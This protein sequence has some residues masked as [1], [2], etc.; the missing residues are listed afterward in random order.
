MTTS[1]GRNDTL[2]PPLL[3]K[4]TAVEPISAR[5]SLIFISIS[6]IFKTQFSCESTLQITSHAHTY[7]KINKAFCFDKWAFFSNFAFNMCIKKTS[8]SNMKWFRGLVLMLLLTITSALSAQDETVADAESANDSEAVANDS[9]MNH[10]DI[11]LITC[12]PHDMIYALYGHTGIRIH[13]LQ[14]GEDL[15]ANW[16]I[17]DQ[18]QSFF[19]VRF[20]FGLTDYR[21]EIETWEG[22]VDRY[23]YFNCGIYE[24]V[25]DLTAQEKRNII[26]AVFENYLPENR[27]YRYNFYYDNCTT[28]ARDIIEKGLEGKLDYREMKEFTP[29]YRELIHLWNENHLWARW[30]NDFLL[31]VGS[32]KAT[33]YRQQQ[34]L[35]DNLK[36]DFHR[37][38][39][40]RNGEA[41]PLVKNEFWA[42]PSQYNY[43]GSSL[44][45]QF[46]RPDAVAVYLIFIALAIT[47]LEKY[48]LKRRLWQFD[49]FLLLLSGIPGLIL[50]LMIFSQH[51]TVRIN[52]Q[53]LVFNPLSLFFAWRII[54]NFRKGKD[55]G[56]TL[57]LEFCFGVALLTNF[58]Q[59]FAE[60][61]IGL[62]LVLFY[63]FMSSY[64]LKENE[65]K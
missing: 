21:M 23:N 48:Q 46:T 4:S 31:G 18:K 32:D 20:A 8:S 13:N 16:G 60:G 27:Y 51:P 52:F 33:D 28:R 12:E 36:K 55:C 42:T 26:N 47:L 24:Q 34:F 10:I 63:R 15:L 45:D 3:Q 11:S 49:A 50:L 1:F 65:K 29:T 62:A 25:L 19:V 38:L 37:A 53:I 61:V 54:N 39:I 17:F 14:T 5:F 57:I 56:L 6:Q 44:L 35:P 7:A 64:G 43:G 22:F 41:R 9:L 59:T 2:I 40:S 30:G 58:W